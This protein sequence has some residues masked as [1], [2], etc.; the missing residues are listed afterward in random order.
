MSIEELWRSF[1]SAHSRAVVVADRALVRDMFDGRQP[2]K[3]QNQPAKRAIAET[4]RECKLVRTVAR[5]A[6]LGVFVL[7]VVLG[8]R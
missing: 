2:E 7:L 5:F 3:S 8:F 1:R 6:G 4:I